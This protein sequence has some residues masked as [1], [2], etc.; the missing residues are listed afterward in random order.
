MIQACKELSLNQCD[1]AIA[2]GIS[3]NLP[4]EVGYFFTENGILSEDGH[5]R[6]FDIN[7]SGTVMSNGAGLIVLKRYEDALANN[8]FIH[9]VIIGYGMNND[10]NLKTGFMA[11]GINGQYSC[12]HSAWKNADIQPNDLDYIETHGTATQLGDPI[13]IYALKKACQSFNMTTPCPVGS[14]KS[15]IGHTIIASGMAA[16]IK[17][18][19]MLQHKAIVPSINFQTLNPNILLEDTPLYIANNYQKLAKTKEYFTAGVSNFGLGGTN[20]HIVLQTF[21]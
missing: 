21:S 5:C 15:N 18:A 6:P 14:V 1:M 8:D 12:I 16:I 11:P 17:T 19:L 10:A 4:Q 2:G 13:E 3:I 7:A 9:A 20:T